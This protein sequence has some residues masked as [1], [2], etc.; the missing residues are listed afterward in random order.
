MFK[1]KSLI[2]FDMD[3]TL[4][5]SMGIWNEVD[6]LLIKELGGDYNIPE[7]EIQEQ[8]D[9]NLKKFNLSENPYTEYSKVLKAKYNSDYSPEEINDMRFSIAQN[10]IINVTDYKPDA[11]NF[12]KKLKE[13]GFII[14]IAS[15]TSS[16]IMEKY[17]TK[18]QNIIQ[19][20]NLDDHFDFIYTKDDVQKTKPNP[21]IY[22]KIF[23]EYHV[24]ADDCL[25]IEDALVGVETANNAGIDCVALYDKYADKEREQINKQSK[26]QVASFSR[27]IEILQNEMN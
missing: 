10:F 12:I 16:R 4:I 22:Y 24:A 20:A 3:G 2:A 1:G 5:D 14:G 11:E 21:E 23:D 19:K 25:V 26:Y 27:L 18:N 17:K 9:S 15:N 8:R 6:R 7:E 13:Y